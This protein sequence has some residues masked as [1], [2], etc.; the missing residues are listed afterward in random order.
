MTSL[1]RIGCDW[2]GVSTELQNDILRD[3][4]GFLGYTITDNALEPYMC[5]LSIAFG[6]DKLMLLPGNDRSGE[7]NKTALLN[8][9]TLFGAVREACH[10]I[11]YV[12]ANSKAMNGVSSSTMIVKVMPWWKTA[13]VNL[14][15][16]VGCLVALGIVGY[17]A[18]Y[19]EAR[20]E[21]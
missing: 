7:L 19:H 15:V 5:G 6:N 2:I 11:L 18:S 9:V 3:E 20:E 17:V 12:Y 14:D 21:Q 4:W 13:L 10:R 8:D 16:I 1:N